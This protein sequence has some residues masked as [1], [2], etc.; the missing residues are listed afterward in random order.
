MKLISWTALLLAVAANI[1]ANAA[2]KRAVASLSPG[3]TESAPL[4]LLRNGY[5]WIGL[6]LA[7]VLLVSFLVALRQIPV[8]VAYLAISALATVGLV[9]VDSTL[10]GLK[11]GLHNVLGMALVIAGLALALKGV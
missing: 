11:L 4:Q 5:L 7:A 2:F 3:A 9:V 6:T 8:S 10:F 1:G